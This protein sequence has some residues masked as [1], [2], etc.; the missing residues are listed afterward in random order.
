MLGGGSPPAAAV[1]VFGL[2][3]G[4]GEWVLLLYFLGVGLM[5]GVWF[6]N[7]LLFC[8]VACVLHTYNFLDSVEVEDH[9]RRRRFLRVCL[10]VCVCDI[11]YCAEI[12]DFF[13]IREDHVILFF[14]FVG[15]TNL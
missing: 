9:D 12:L 8:E 6:C 11:L 10:H 13:H 3:V 2:L 15:K 4:G 1:L 7:E 5:L 14:L